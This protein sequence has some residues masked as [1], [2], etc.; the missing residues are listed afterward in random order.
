MAGEVAEYPPELGEVT[1]TK[2]NRAQKVVARRMSASKAEVPEFAVTVQIEMTAAKELRGSLKRGD[3]PAPSFNDMIVTACASCLRRHPA[4][5]S[6]FAGDSIA[7][8]ENVNIGIAVA[9]DGLLVVPTLFDADK[10]TL[11]E[12]AA[13]SRSS[14]TRAREK[15]LTPQDMSGG[16]FTVSNLGMYGVDHFTAIVNQPQAAILAIGAIRADF[17]RCGDLPI[18]ADLMSVTLVSDHRVVYGADAAA[19]L[20]S[21]KSLLEAPSTLLEINA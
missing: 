3:E 21:L 6:S 9:V 18:P 4:I 8:F 1:L 10:K 7:T 19:F 16:S 11:F 13:C 2:L 5:N 15:Q 14:V 17:V 20:Q 12:I